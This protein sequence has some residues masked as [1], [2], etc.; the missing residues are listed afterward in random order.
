MP[1]HRRK[2]LQQSQVRQPEQQQVKL[3]RAQARVRTLGKRLGSLL[4]QQ[5]WLQVDRLRMLQRQLPMQHGKPEP[6]V[7]KQQR[8][9]VKRLGQLWWRVEVARLMP[10]RPPLMQPRTKADQAKL[11]PKLQGQQWRMQEAHLRKQAPLRLVQPLL[12]AQ[13]QLRLRKLQARLLGLLWWPTVAMSLMLR[14]RQ[15]KLL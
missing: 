15:G 8:Q 4:E 6:V 13:A 1:V 10:V 12:E 9:Q 2:M 11:R 5:W 7:R 3:Q 14:S